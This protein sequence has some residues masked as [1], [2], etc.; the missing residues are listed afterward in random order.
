[1]SISFAGRLHNRCSKIVL[2]MWLCMI[3]IVLQIFTATLSSW[4]TINQLNPKVPS[5]FKH[6]GYQ[7]GSFLKDF[8][9]QRYNCTGPQ[10]LSSYE[11]FRNALSNGSV[12]AIFDILPYVDIFLAKYGS[13][14][15]MK[16]GPKIQ[17]SGIAFVSHFSSLFLSLL[18]VIIEYLPLSLLGNCC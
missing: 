5:S 10:P 9:I 6:V 13:E 16:I 12:N 17:E 3:F 18:H 1:M 2:V 7:N 15:Y 8:I 11:E 14:D 4:L